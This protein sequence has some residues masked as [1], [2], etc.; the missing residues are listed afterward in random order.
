[1]KK[2]IYL[3]IIVMLFSC[4]LVV[5]QTNIASPT[6]NDSIISIPS[7][8]GDWFMEFVDYSDPANPMISVLSFWRMMNL[9]AISGD[10]N[11]MDVW[12]F[13]GDLKIPPQTPSTENEAG[14]IWQ[15]GENFYFIQRTWNGTGYDYSSQKVLLKSEADELY[16][17]SEAGLSDAYISTT[18]NQLSIAGNKQTLGLWEFDKIKLPGHATTLPTATKQYQVYV[19]G[20]GTNM[21][22][23]AADENLDWQLVGGSSSGGLPST[24][25][26]SGINSTLIATSGKWQ[27]Y[28][29]E[30]TKL[31]LKSSYNPA[32]E[33]Q[34]TLYFSGSTVA[35]GLYAKRNGTVYQMPSIDAM[36]A[37]IKIEAIDYTS[38]AISTDEFITI[39]FNSNKTAQVIS[40][41]GN[42]APEI[43]FINMAVGKTASFIIN[44]CNEPV[45]INSPTGW[46]VKYPQISVPTFS[47][48]KQYD[49]FAKCM[50][51]N[52][53][54]V[55]VQWR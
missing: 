27:P 11:L 4:D 31:L 41:Q 6:K 38:P 48:G 12:R 47:D 21:K 16:A 54:W 5:A 35:Q 19:I 15:D 44:D 39:D 7:N 51:D 10:Q 28:E 24:G 1:M 49:L 42:N 40:T 3:L 37:N 46:T 2:I 34:L 18:T 45:T 32:T 26:M 36:K 50:A 52:E 22:I 33:N 29:L 23:Y 43:S 25:Y 13:N 53:I 9:M 14:F 17:L 20:T 8:P 55:H 30:A